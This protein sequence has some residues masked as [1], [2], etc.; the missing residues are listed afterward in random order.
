MF[1]PILSTFGD[2]ILFLSQLQNGVSRV[3]FYYSS[4]RLSLILFTVSNAAIL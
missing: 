2:I 3:V 4:T 1:T